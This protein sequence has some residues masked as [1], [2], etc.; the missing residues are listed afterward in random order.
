MIVYVDECGMYLL[1]AAVRTWAPRGETPV[2]EQTLSRDHLSII[3]AVTARGKLLL[4]VHKHAIR[5]VDC[6]RFLKHLVRHLGRVLVIWDGA[7][8]HRGPAVRKYLATEAK[9]KVH[10]ECLPGYA[11]DLNGQEGVWHLLKHHQ[12]GNVCA[13]TLKEL[14]GDLRRA[15]KRLR[16]KLPA[17][18]GCFRQPEHV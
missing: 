11:P 7:P 14:T 6:V 12:L 2:L 4:Q 1:P 17:L 5:S 13:A 18:K 16:H 3:G 10:L 9:G 8:I 15:I